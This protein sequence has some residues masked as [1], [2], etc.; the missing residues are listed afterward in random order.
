LAAVVGCCDAGSSAMAVRSAPPKA[1]AP[2]A[3]TVVARAK[4]RVL[5][6]M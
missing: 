5:P 2:A 3:I 1:S 4:A 6:E